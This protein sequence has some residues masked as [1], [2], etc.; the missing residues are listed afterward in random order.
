MNLD[1]IHAVD[2]QTFEVVELGLNPFKAEDL[3]EA[4]AAPAL[5]LMLLAFEEVAGE[6]PRAEVA[7]TVALPSLASAQ[8]S[9]LLTMISIL[10]LG[11]NS[12]TYSAPL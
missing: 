11:I 3:A 8:D 2:P 12:T 9:S 1:Q 10:T 4:L 5:D 7:F 6:A